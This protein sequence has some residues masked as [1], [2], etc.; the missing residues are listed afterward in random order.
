MP[1]LKISPQ[2]SLP[3]DAVTETFAILAKRRAGKSKAIKDGP[4]GY[5]ASDFVMYGAQ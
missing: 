2:L 4:G 1:G 3:L 5:V